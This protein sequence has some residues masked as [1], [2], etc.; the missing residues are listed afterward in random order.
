M[1]IRPAVASDAAG[2]GGVNHTAWRQAYTGLVPDSFWRTFTLAR[3][4]KVWRTILQ[5]PD[6]S[7]NIIVVADAAPE[8]PPNQIL[9]YACSGP[10]LVHGDVPKARGFELYSIYVLSAHHGIGLG[11]QLLDTVL[12]DRPAVLWVAR[13]NPRARAFYRRNGFVADGQADTHG[14]E[15]GSIEEIRMVR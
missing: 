1:V 4:Q 8:G 6:D 13:H 14:E 5:S 15:F 2:I 11:Q 7:G 10:E 12:G 3:R 9:G